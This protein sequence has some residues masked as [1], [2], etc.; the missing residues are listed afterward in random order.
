M[1]SSS[2]HA[3]DLKGLAKLFRVNERNGCLAGEV[4]FESLHSA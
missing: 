2:H 3:I 4:A 1:R